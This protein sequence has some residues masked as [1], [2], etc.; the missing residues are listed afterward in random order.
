[1][2]IGGKLPAINSLYDISKTITNLEKRVMF[3]EKNGMD[4]MSRKEL[5]KDL[6]KI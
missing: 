5:T 2:I 1:M 6:I 4:M 3:Y